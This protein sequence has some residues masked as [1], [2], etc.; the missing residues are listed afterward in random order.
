MA[1]EDN[2]QDEIQDETQDE[3]QEEKEEK[4][5]PSKS[6]SSRGKKPP[7]KSKHNNVQVWEKYKDGKPK[8]DFCPRCG[9]GTFLAQHKNRQTCGKCGYSHIKNEDNKKEKKEVPKQE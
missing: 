2:V 7:S 1:E 4:P 5:T 9:P 8:Q 3:A 6:R